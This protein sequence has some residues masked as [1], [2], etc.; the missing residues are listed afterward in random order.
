M[1]TDLLAQAISPGVFAE[2][3]LTTKWEGVFGQNIKN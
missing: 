1:F 3:K 2:R